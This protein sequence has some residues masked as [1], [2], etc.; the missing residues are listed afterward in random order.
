M[1]VVT[2]LG[3]LQNLTFGQGHLVTQV[4]HAAYR[5]TRID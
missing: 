4:G 5:A 3:Q 1:S 2:S